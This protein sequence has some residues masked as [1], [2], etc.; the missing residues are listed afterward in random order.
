MKATEMLTKINAL[1]SIK[2]NL[3]QLVLDNGTVIESESFAGGESVFIVTD[4]ERVALPIG[5]YMIEDGRKLVVSEEGVIESIGEGLEK[6]DEKE[7]EEEVE[8]E[9]EVIV[10]VPD[11]AAKEVAEVIEAVV[12]VVSP[13]IEEIKE[14]VEELK[15][16]FET[17]PEAE[18][19]GYKDGIKDE[20]EDVKE[21][22][23]KQPARKPINHSPERKQSKMKHLYS[24][25]NKGVSTLDRVLNKLNNFK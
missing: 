19:E 3:A 12:E 9:E 10:E 5:D 23:S 24:Q 8:M 15:K 14:E 6:E 11:E 20:K 18:E 1:L 2:V 4:D 21:K 13:L 7:E 22:L 16:K 17:V 25:K